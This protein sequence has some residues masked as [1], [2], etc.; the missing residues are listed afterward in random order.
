[1]K[2]YV[3]VRFQ[4]SNGDSLFICTNELTR[5]CQVLLHL[6]SHCRLGPSCFWFMAE[7]VAALVW[8]AQSCPVQGLLF[9]RSTGSFSLLWWES[10]VKQSW[11]SGVSRSHSSNDSLCH[12]SSS[13]PRQRR[14]RW[15]MWQQPSLEQ[16]CGAI[17]S[18]DFPQ[19]MTGSVSDSCCPRNLFPSPPLASHHPQAGFVSFSQAG[20]LQGCGT[21]AATFKEPKRSRLIQSLMWRFLMQ[22]KTCSWPRE[23]RLR[24]WGVENCNYGTVHSDPRTEVRGSNYPWIWNLQKEGQINSTWL[25]D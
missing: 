6:Q 9:V 16:R 14:L 24:L 19:V 15:R 13:W 10:D 22:M 25:S 18:L 5:A 3:N 17:L 2:T 8:Q 21:A 4:F 12:Q 20:F 1:M 11:L 7:I 23:R